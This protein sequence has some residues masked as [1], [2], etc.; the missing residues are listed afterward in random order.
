MLDSHVVRNWGIGNTLC[1]AAHTSL[2]L[3]KC[4]R[5]Q[6]RR[7]ELDQQPYKVTRNC[8]ILTG[9]IAMVC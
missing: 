2:Q 3:P 6:Y 7:L 9:S 1:S 5:M 4:L 8:F